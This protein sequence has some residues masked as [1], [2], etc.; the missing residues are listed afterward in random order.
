M[1]ADILLTSVA[2]LAA[3]LAGR[4]AETPVIS[5]QQHASGA[6][7]V[8][9]RVRTGETAD[10]ARA[11]LTD[12]ANIPRFMPGVRASEVVERQD[13]LVRVRQEAVS[14]YM[15]FSKRIHLA[16]DIEETSHV[17]RFRDRSNISF[18]VYE[19]AWTLTPQEDG[20]ELAYE[21]V[22]KPAFSVPGFVIRKLLNRDARAM[23]ERLQAEIAARGQNVLTAR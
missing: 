6:Y 16:L 5:V 3:T 23:L 8:T 17:I 12:Y 10:V 11:V 15:F 1:R 18:H 2:L 13:G 20:T 22:A 21:L 7:V 9:A 4:A 19:G 14:E